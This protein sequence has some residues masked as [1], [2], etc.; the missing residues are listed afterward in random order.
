MYRARIA[1]PVREVVEVLVDGSPVGVVWDAPWRID[2]GPAAGPGSVLE[3]RV[4][5]TTANALA[6][7]TTIAEWAAEAERLHGRRFRMQALGR[8]LDGVS[9]GLAGVPVLRS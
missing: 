9:S 7:D 8:T 1:P 3:L 5:N 4:S 2:L 6:A